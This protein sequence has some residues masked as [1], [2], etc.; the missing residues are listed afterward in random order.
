MFAF[1]AMTNLYGFNGGYKDE[2]EKRKTRDREKFYEKHKERKY[3]VRD[4]RKEKENT[5]RRWYGRGEGE[6]T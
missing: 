2:Q 4:T 3:D 5:K 6:D 1:V